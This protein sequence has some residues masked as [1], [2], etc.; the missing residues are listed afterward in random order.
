MDRRLK[1]YREMN[2]LESSQCVNDFFKLTIGEQ[3]MLTID[4]QME[5]AKAQLLMQDHVEQAGKPCCINLIT[6]EDN[7][8]L[9][10]LA[11]VARKAE[12][13]ARKEQEAV[14]DAQND[15]LTESE[16]G[17]RATQREQ[18]SSEE[19]DEV[20]LLLRKEEQDAERRQIEETEA[21]RV[22]AEEDKVRKEKEEAERIK[23]EKIRDEERTLLDQKS[24][25]IRQYLMDKVVPHLTEG[26]IELCKNVP[27]DPIDNLS[28]FLLQ[29]A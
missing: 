20:V 29:R 13:A 15:D 3:N 12:K 16:K 25:P 9:R 26:L 1:V 22:A 23:L 2:P 5:E 14:D 4:C 24:Q 28:T 18:E 8:Y 7:K 11:K 19:E 27:E 10:S 17:R 6:D 21:A